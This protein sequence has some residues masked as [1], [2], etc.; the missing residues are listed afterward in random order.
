[1]FAIAAADEGGDLSDKW[2][3]RIVRGRYFTKEFHGEV[4]Q[5]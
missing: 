2:R 1:L 5:S 3:V 4:E